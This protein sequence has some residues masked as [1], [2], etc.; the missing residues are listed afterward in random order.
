MAENSRTVYKTLTKK[1]RLHSVV[2][3]VIR[4][5]TEEF[6]VYSRLRARDFYV[7]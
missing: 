1:C 4:P 3:A 6:W 7:R 5:K 2:G